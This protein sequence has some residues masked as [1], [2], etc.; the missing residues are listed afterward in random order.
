MFLMTCMQFIQTE[1]AEKVDPQFIERMG[2]YVSMETLIQ[3]MLYTSQKWE[4]RKK[5]NNSFKS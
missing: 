5:K 2:G 3:G 1:M 4:N